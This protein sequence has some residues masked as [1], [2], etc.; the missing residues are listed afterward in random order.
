MTKQEG[1]PR[2]PG[3]A[4]AEPGL[5][6]GAQAEPWVS[7]GGRR[8]YSGEQR[9]E[10]LDAFH[11]SGQTVRAFCA[12]RGVSSSTLNRWVSRTSGKR[13]KPRGKVRR[14]FT[15]EE[16][17]AAVEGFYKSGRTRTDFAALW[18][19]S[20]D[21]LSKWIR[22]YEAEG[23][24]GL[25][26]RKGRSGGA[27]R[28]IPEGVRKEIARTKRR[29][30][31]FGL[32]KVRD[33]LGRFHGVKVSVG[34][35]RKTLQEAGIE[36]EPAP[37][38][39]PRRK[40]KP[41]RRFERARPGE[42]WQSDITSFLLT[43]HSRRVYLIVF[44]DDHSRYVVSWG[45]FTHQRAEI[46]TE[47]LLEGIARFGKPREVL[48][49]QG[50]QYFAWRGKS[51]FQKLLVREGIQHVVSRTHHP[52][53][54]GK[55]E[56]LWKTVDEELWQRARPQ[57]LVEARRRMEHFFRHYNHFRPH[58]GIGGL[59]PAD[60]LFGAEES[61][62][63]ALEE[64]MAANE[65]SLA[66]GNEPRRPVFLFGQIGDRQVSLH[67]ERGR[68]VIHTSDGETEELSMDAMGLAMEERDGGM[69]NDASEGQT[70]L[71]AQAQAGAL[72]AAAETGCAGEGAVAE[73]DGGAAEPG[74]PGV[75]GGAR[76]LDG[77]HQ[78]GGAGQAAGG[79][80]DSCVAAVPEGVER[81]AGGPVA[82][83]EAQRQGGEHADGSRGRPE[84]PAPQDRGPG[85]QAGAY[86][87]PG[88]GAQGAAVEPGPGRGEGGR[89][90]SPTTGRRGEDERRQGGIPSSCEEGSEDGSWL[91]DRSDGVNDDG[92]RSSWE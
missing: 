50:R 43:R 60:R 40:A 57:D 26:T 89:G 51:A 61:L 64:Q 78:E 33:F 92:S 19:I 76:V 5:P 79:A 3:S 14:N 22:R 35:V 27:K 7:T 6:G 38:R 15:P 63:K 47:T 72:R 20:I 84:G 81:D 4:G 16:R 68:V 77:A 44:L 13:A 37:K 31:T 80:A 75:H 9:R 56:R 36:S 11:R 25:E 2:G 32:R 70:Q 39:K 29:F 65:L 8:I 46:A 45:L 34:S 18:G 86:G 88:A 52:Q 24:K 10:L 90:C 87:G 67:G 62:R 1:P 71:Q 83:A 82:P 58:Q 28:T 41:P 59:V 49:D 73:C 30:P 12:S 69:R 48:T 66:L 17:R 91:R 23:P 55:C 53:T 21:T 42:L 74:S 85:G 54:L